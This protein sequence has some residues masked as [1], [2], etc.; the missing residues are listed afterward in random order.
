M[1]QI[2]RFDGNNFHHFSSGCSPTRIFS[3][4]LLSRHQRILQSTQ[5]SRASM[6]RIWK[7]HLI[8][9]IGCHKTVVSHYNGYASILSFVVSRLLNHFT[10]AQIAQCL[11]RQFSIRVAYG[12]S[13]RSSPTTTRRSYILFCNH[14]DL[15][16]I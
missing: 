15:R 4:L 3:R 5:L 16:L 1:S 11:W 8:T 13:L 12:N 2:I 9:W 14:L 7:V 10:F 6:L